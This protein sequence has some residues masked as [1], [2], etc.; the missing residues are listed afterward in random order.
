[1]KVLWLCVSAGPSGRAIELVGLRLLAYWD[2]RFESRRRHG[3]MSVVS[4][5]WC[6]VLVSA[7]GWSLLQRSHA[8]C[9][10]SEYDCEASITRGSRPTMGCYSMENNYTFSLTSLLLFVATAAYIDCLLNG[11]YRS[12]LHCNNRIN[13]RLATRP[14]TDKC[15]TLAEI[16]NGAVYS[17]VAWT[18]D[19]R[20]YACRPVRIN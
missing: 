4:V 8:E 11:G 17:D 7:S 14:E 12:L 13:D 3:C 5:V 2:Y 1:V 20:E 18:V 16:I 19:F 15:W 6:R 9:G 10:V